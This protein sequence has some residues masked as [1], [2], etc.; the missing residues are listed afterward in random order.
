MVLLAPDA[1][2]KFARRL[3]NLRIQRGFDRARFFA[4]TLGIEENR[5]TR[6]ERAEVEP[7]LTLIQKMC[8]TL[9]VTPN[10]LLS[11]GEIADDRGF[12][13]APGM[14]EAG[15][16]EPARGSERDSGGPDPV[17]SLAWR[18]ASETVAMRVAQLG[19]K[20]AADPLEIIRETSALFAELQAKPFGAVAEIVRDPA[21][22]SADAARKAALAELI[23]SFTETVSAGASDKRRR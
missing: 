21:L 11:F 22:K 2:T 6:Y 12:A 20:A 5:Y 1:R 7:S 17:G 4:K 10:E 19:K 18:L 9:R 16:G 8:E 15:P 14:A 23:Q 3:K 13:P